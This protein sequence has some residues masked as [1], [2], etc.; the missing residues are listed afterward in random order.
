MQRQTPFSDILYVNKLA[1]CVYSALHT[2]SLALQRATYK[3]L[4]VWQPGCIHGNNPL[5]I[6]ERMDKMSPEIVSISFFQFS[7]CEKKIHKHWE[8]T[9]KMPTLK[10]NTALKC[11]LERLPKTISLIQYCGDLPRSLGGITATILRA[12][13]LP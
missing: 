13:E 12:C 11:N 4:S 10:I 7:L 1:Q 2:E 9:Q 3:L 6:S 5:P 8:L